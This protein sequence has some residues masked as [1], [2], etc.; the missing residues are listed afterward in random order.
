MD[1]VIPLGG[2]KYKVPANMEDRKELYECIRD[3]DTERFKTFISKNIPELVLAGWLDKTQ[4][5]LVLIMH[6]MRSQY[7]GLGE[8]FVKSRNFLRAKQFGYCPVEASRKPICNTCRW[9][10]EVPSGEER[11]CMHLGSIPQDIACKGYE[12]AGK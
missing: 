9:F 3:L 10:R 2:K 5:Q 7:I 12:A 4:E 1:N 6:E 8:D 11:A